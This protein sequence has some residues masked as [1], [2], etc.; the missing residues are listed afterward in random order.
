MKLNQFRLI[1]IT[2]FHIELV[3][4]NI[5]DGAHK[6][7][8]ENESDCLQATH[9]QRVGSGI[10]E[11]CKFTQWRYLI[12]PAPCNAGHNIRH[13]FEWFCV[14]GLV[15][16]FIFIACI[17]ISRCLFK[18]KKP[19]DFVFLNILYFL[20]KFRWLYDFHV[21]R[22]AT[23]IGLLTIMIV[24]VVCWILEFL[25]A[26]SQT[27]PLV[28]VVAMQHLI[29][30]FDEVIYIFTSNFLKM[31]CFHFITEMSMALNANSTSLK[32]VCI[33]ILFKHPWWYL[34]L[35]CKSWLVVAVVVSLLLW[36]PAV[37][38]AAAD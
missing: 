19:N 28:K 38:A 11:W 27:H 5:G 20:I 29:L 17:I 9:D 7:N 22:V 25:H 2:T 4:H 18:Y 8:H 15:F 36:L 6:K 3:Y 31:S 13:C 34:I 26:G 12:W 16:G 33:I 35:S 30:L 32:R 24:K 1:R 10:G 37:A 14:K 21:L 23:V